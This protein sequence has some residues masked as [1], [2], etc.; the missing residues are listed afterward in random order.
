M[1]ADPAVHKWQSAILPENAKKKAG[2][3]P[4]LCC[5]FTTCF[6]YQV[7]RN[8]KVSSQSVPVNTELLMIL[9]MPV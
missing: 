7:I 3:N 5:I 8:N 1:A 9:M 4:T 2:L 6:Y